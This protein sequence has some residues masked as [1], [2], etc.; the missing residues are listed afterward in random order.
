MISMIIGGFYLG[1]ARDTF[2]RFSS[3][4]RRRNLLRYFLEVSFWMCQTF[5][6]FYILY[7]VNAGEL[8][9][10]V[11]IACVL[12]FSMYQVMFAQFYK[13]ILE[14][15]I[16]ILLVIYRFC[17]T[18]IGLLI[19]TPVCWIIYIVLKIVQTIIFTLF[20]MIRFIFMP[21]GWAIKWVY[22]LLPNKLR[23]NVYKIVKFYS[24]IKNT[25]MNWLKNI[26]LKRR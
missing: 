26:L 18:V 11:F 7:R 14:Q 20:F 22:L 6:L 12:G 16:R 21:V 17:K 15:V 1:L 24:I 10:Y 8:R 2:Q 9:F 4:W 19:I 25:C 3:Y 23:G 5:I 13:R